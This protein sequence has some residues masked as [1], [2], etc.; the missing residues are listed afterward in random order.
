MTLIFGLFV[1]W[2]VMTIYIDKT[3]DNGELILPQNASS[4]FI[5]KKILF[6]YSLFLNNSVQQKN[7]YF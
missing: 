2:P 7:A 4:I 3:F 5:Q 1:V 6:Q